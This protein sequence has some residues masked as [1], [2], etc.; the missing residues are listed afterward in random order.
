[1]SEWIGVTIEIGGAIAAS[2][3][4]GLVNAINK[5]LDNIVGLSDITSP[6]NKK[7]LRID[8]TANYGMCPKIIKFCQKNKLSFSLHCEAKD[9]YEAHTTYW[10]PG[11]IQLVYNTDIN[12]APIVH[13]VDVIPMINL[14]YALIEEGE[15][16]IP[17]F[18]NDEV[19]GDVAKVGL[20][21]GKRGFLKALKK[22]I[23]RIIPRNNDPIP[24]F[25]VER[26]K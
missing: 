25:V 9:E 13:A 21:S 15:D 8:G 2:L 16:A 23:E 1:M 20:K 19:I 7:P 4:E 5:D 24:P 14:M 12:G 6:D 3:T 22:E 11:M 17:R 10:K 26:N 18:I